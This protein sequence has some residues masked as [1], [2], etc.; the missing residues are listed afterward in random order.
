M[1]ETLFFALALDAE[2][3]LDLEGKVMGM[4]VRFDEVFLEELEFAREI[5]D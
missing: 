5:I 2:D 1:R 3:V 4:P